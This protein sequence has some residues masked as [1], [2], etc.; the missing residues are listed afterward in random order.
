[1]LLYVGLTALLGNVDRYADHFDLLELRFD[2]GS[3]PSPKSLRRLRASAPERLV[4]CLLVVPSL[5]SKALEDPERLKPAL[6]A[7]EMLKAGWIVLQTGSEIGPSARVRARLAALATRC[8]APDRRVAWEARGPWEP[9][10]ARQVAR[11]TGITLIEDLSMVEAPPT[12]LIYTRLRVPGPGAALRSGALERLASQIAGAEECLVVIEGRAS[13]RARSKIQQALRAARALEDE[14]QL[15]DGLDDDAFGEDD[16]DDE[17]LEQDP[18]SE[19]EQDGDPWE[20]DPESE[21]G[22]RDDGSGSSR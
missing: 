11:A 21:D 22:A 16:G 9:E 2:P 14:D 7:A 17:E 13:A 4:F 6:E 3:P 8:A 19:D 12:S 20:A 1:M 18:E 15:A 5:T 10:V